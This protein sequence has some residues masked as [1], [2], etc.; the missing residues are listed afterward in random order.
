MGCIL[1]LSTQCVNG[2]HGYQFCE[3]VLGQQG[4]SIYLHVYPFNN[5]LSGTQFIA[6]M[7]NIK[8]VYKMFSSSKRPS[9]SLSYFF[10]KCVAI[11]VKIKNL[12]SR[13]LKI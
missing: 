8:Y 7:L 6:N 9:L 11:T 10:R 5:L 2:R 4:R 13:M 3:H 1:L 12:Y